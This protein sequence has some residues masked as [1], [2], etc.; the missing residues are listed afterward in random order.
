MSSKTTYIAA[1]QEVSCLC[2]DQVD[3]V[4]G[5]L[6]IP[7][8]WLKLKR[9]IVARVMQLDGEFSLLDVISEIRSEM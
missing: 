9:V 4:C 3:D 5:L 7:M 1:L 8:T 2:G 6:N